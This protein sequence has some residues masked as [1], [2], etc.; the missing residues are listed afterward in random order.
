MNTTQQRPAEFPDPRVKPTL[1]VPETARWFN[2]GTAA[3][4]EG[5]RTGRI[6]A[7]RVGAHKLRVPTAAVA[8]LLG[9]DDPA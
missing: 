7:V 5:I 1:S 6:P 3:I 8:R 9:L 4:Y 2:T